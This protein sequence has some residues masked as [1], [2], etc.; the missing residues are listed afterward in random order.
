MS[1]HW[2]LAEIDPDEDYLSEDYKFTKNHFLTGGYEFG[3]KEILFLRN[4]YRWI[5]N[6]EFDL[7]K[8]EFTSGMGVNSRRHFECNVYYSLLV[9]TYDD[10]D[11][12]P[13]SRFG[14]SI[15]FFNISK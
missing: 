5:L 7:N 10:V 8:F 9:Y 6:N 2:A 15:N 12:D 11:F 13:T 1:L 4:G 3:I 14:M